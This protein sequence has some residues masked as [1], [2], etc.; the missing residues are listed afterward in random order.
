MKQVGPCAVYYTHTSFIFIFISVFM[1]HTLNPKYQYLRRSNKYEFKI[2]DIRELRTGIWRTLL[3]YGQFSKAVL[4]TTPHV[5][6]LP[7]LT[8]RAVR[9]LFTSLV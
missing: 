5:V 6:L 7:P 4:K 8:Q 2:Q 1:S 9:L 3:R